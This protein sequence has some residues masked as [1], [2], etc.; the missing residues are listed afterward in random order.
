MFNKRQSCTLKNRMLAGMK[1]LELI[2]DCK[3]LGDFHAEWLLFVQKLSPAN[4]FQKPEWLATWWSHFGSGALRVMVFRHDGNVA[5]VLPCFLHPWNGRRQ[6]TLV[7]SGI[8]D[9]L[10]PLFE[11]AYVDEMLELIRAELRRGADWDICDWQDLS[12]DTPLASLGTVVKETACSVIP[13]NQP[14][15]A[16]LGTR[17][18]DL[19]RNL[20]RYREKAEA[21]GCVSFEVTES[22]DAD[23]MD[24]LIKLHGA[25]WAKAGEAGMIEENRSEAFLRDIVERFGAGGLLRI[26]TLRFADRIAAILLAFRDNTTIY[27]Y[28]SAFDPQYE[29]FGF[30]RELLAQALR[31]AHERG[32]RQWN[33]LRGEEP[34]KFSWGAQALEKCRVVIRS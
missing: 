6:M 19:R 26:F 3:R 25:R 1:A 32:Y 33:F 22:A 5:G 20:R 23:L 17:P 24:A 2:D 31:Y 8:S 29:Q 18:K 30:G 12:R 21:I 4:P 11:P 28:L 34:Y 16:F 10:D 9:Y 13:I 7:G 15:E 14:F 27:S